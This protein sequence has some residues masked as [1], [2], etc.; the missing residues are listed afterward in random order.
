MQLCG[1]KVVSIFVQCSVIYPGTERTRRDRDGRQ[2]QIRSD[3]TSWAG[4]QSA[5]S[6]SEGCIQ[7]CVVRCKE[8]HR[9]SADS[10][11]AVRTDRRLWTHAESRGPPPHLHVWPDEWHVCGHTLSPEDLRL[12]YTFDQTSDDTPNHYEAYSDNNVCEQVWFVVVEWRLTRHQYK[13]YC[14]DVVR[15]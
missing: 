8:P 12:I 1:G 6:S 3:V 5:R 4:S 11:P 2:A 9:R 10:I 14:D 15:V 7:D 13:L